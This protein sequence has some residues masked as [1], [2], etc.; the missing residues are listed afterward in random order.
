[1]LGGRVIIAA[2]STPVECLLP[3][4]V[5]AV[6]LLQVEDRQFRVDVE[7]PEIVVPL[8]LSSNDDRVYATTGNFATGTLM[9]RLARRRASCSISRITVAA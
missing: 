1:M 2:D 6:R 4:M 9:V 7:A 5:L 8:S 3:R